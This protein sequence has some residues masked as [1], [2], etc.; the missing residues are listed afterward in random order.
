MKKFQFVPGEG[1]SEMSESEEMLTELMKDPVVK[2]ARHM[3][4]VCMDKAGDVMTAGMGSRVVGLGLAEIIRD[5]LLNEV[6]GSLENYD[7]E[8]QEGDD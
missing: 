6:M 3:V 2:N 4:V 8:G 7:D 5:R 1:L